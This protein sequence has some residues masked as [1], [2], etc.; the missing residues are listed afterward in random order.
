MQP[1]R[2]VRT[3]GAPR[4]RKRAHPTIAAAENLGMNLALL[5]LAAAIAALAAS[6]PVVA[7][8]T[9]PGG[10]PAAATEYGEAAQPRRAAEDESQTQRAPRRK[11]SPPVAGQSSRGPA[12]KEECVW[13]GKRIVNL[14]SRDDAMAANDFMP[15]YGQFGCPGDHLAK[16]FGC[17]VTNTDP[18]EN[19]ALADRIDACWD[20]PKAVI[21][22]EPTAAESELRDEQPKERPA[23]PAR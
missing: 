15:F 2:S 6:S 22:Q 7:A 17:V 1:L 11:P 5:P 4:I 14:L 10:K 21:A 13:V 16:A 18:S 19:E 23:P 20:D 9:T 8:D 3:F 12:F